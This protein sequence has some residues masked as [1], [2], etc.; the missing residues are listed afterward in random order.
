MLLLKV[1]AVVQA[2]AVTSPFIAKSPGALEALKSAT[3]LKSLRLNTLITGQSGTGKKTLAHY[4]FPHATIINAHNFTDLIEL[5]KE[6]EDLIITDF[7]KLANPEMFK[8][9]LDE[10][11]TKIVAISKM[12]LPEHLYNQFFTLSIEIPPLSERQ[13]DIAPICEKFREE[14]VDILGESDAG[15]CVANSLDIKD[16]AHSLKRSILI[17][18]LFKSLTKDE[19]EGVLEDYL[20]QNLDGDNAYRD[21]LPLFDVPLIN[22]G[23]KKYKSQLK[24]SEVLGLNR[25]TL[26]KKIS[27]NSKDII[28]E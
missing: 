20:F 22:A 5:V 4:I 3:L 25:N 6:N 17:Q 11:T 18:S 7:E 1:V 15:L 23:L 10:S 21:N 9:I 13:E 12:T 16:N 24:L 28:Y 2:V 8:E 26:R 14:F 27:Q 19:I